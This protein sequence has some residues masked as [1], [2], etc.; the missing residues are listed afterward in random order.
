MIGYDMVPVTTSETI[1][2]GAVSA[3]FARNL[4]AARH[5]RVLSPISKA[6]G[7][8]YRGWTQMLAATG[9]GSPRV[10]AVCLPAEVPPAD[11]E[12]IARAARRLLVGTLPMVL[13]VGSH[14]PRKNHLTVLHAAE[15]L[16]REGHR[17][18]LTFMGGNSWSSETFQATLSGLARAGRPVE[19]IS[20]AGDDLLWGGVPRRALH[21]L[22]VAQ[23][24]VRAPARGVTGLWHAGGDVEL[25]VD[26]R[27][28]RARRRRPDGGPS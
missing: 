24:R 10:E 7:E 28:R 20:A 13:V 25:R 26:A 6:A 9:F 16:W 4:S 21:R 5:A 1:Q 12:Q 8:E 17:F 22:P 27:D 11:P 15:L 18:S 3:G 23:R 14:E 2:A 19:S